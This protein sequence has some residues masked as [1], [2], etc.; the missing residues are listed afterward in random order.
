MLMVSCVGL[1]FY[2]ES[3]TGCLSSKNTDLINGNFTNRL[4]PLVKEIYELFINEETVNNFKEEYC[5]IIINE[6]SWW[7]ANDIYSREFTN[8]PVILQKKYNT[9]TKEIN[10]SLSLAE[11]KYLITLPD[12][13]LKIIKSLLNSMVKKLYSPMV[14]TQIIK[15]LIYTFIV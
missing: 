6:I 3:I 13:Y 15:N 12:K 5:K 11:R 9:T 4:H 7:S 8:I 14:V 2:L 1:G 10:N